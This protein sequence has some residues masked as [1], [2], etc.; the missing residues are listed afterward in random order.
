MFDVDSKAYF[1]RGICYWSSES[2]FSF[3]FHYQR[4][5]LYSLVYCSLKESNTYDIHEGGIP[6]RCCNHYYC[7]RL[8]GQ[9][10]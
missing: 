5:L 2:S 10:I 9:V 1:V 7:S 4:L 8:G 3:T 6:E